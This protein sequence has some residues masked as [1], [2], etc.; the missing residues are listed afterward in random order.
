MSEETLGIFSLGV[1]AGAAWQWWFYT[2]DAQRK[3]ERYHKAL[4]KVFKI[5]ENAG[6]VPPSDLL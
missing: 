4:R 3:A 1:I 6:I 5:L 2:Y